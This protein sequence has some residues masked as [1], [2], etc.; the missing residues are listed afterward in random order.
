MRS[1]LEKYS[2]IKRILYFLRQKPLNIPLIELITRAVETGA[3]E[4]WMVVGIVKI[5]AVFN[6]LLICKGFSQSF[7]VS[8]HESRQFILR[9]HQN[10]SS[11]KYFHCIR[12]FS[13]F[14]LTINCINLFR[15]IF[16]REN[17]F[18]YI[19]NDSFANFKN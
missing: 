1:V 13:H 9:V 11:M 14:E 2:F 6:H 19:L 3:H 4:L 5:F 18:E 8:N 16:F 10:F 7:E 15:D 17:W 12:W